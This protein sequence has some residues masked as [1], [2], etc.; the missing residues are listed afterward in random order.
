MHAVEPED[1]ARSTDRGIDHAHHGGDQQL[2][3]RRAY[4]ADS[5]I[6]EIPAPAENPLHR[7][8]EHVERKHVER[9]VQHASVQESVGDELPRREPGRRAAGAGA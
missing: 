7:A 2:G 8:A 5:V 3:E 9:Q 6:N 4:D 1:A